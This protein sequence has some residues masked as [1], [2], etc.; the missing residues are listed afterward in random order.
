MAKEARELPLDTQLELKRLMAGAGTPLEQVK[1][2]IC[3][4]C[5][6]HTPLC[7]MMMDI[8]LRPECLNNG[9]TFVCRGL[10]EYTIKGN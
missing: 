4:G 3:P 6:Y 8:H 7:D 9:A 5:P 2:E 1:A 10:R